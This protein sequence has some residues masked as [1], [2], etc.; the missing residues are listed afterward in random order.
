MYKIGL[1]KDI[2]SDTYGDFC[3]LMMVLAKGKRAEE[4]FIIYYKVIDQNSW[5]LYDAVVKR[6]GTDIPKWISIMTECSTCHLQK[7]VERYRSYSPCN[8]E[9]SV[10]KEVEGD[11][12][13]LS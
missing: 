12:K 10:K 4:G 13:M 5:D 3:K 7:V 11:W 9:E 1:E 6:K 2:V 8:M